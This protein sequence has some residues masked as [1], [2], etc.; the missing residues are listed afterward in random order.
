MPNKEDLLRNAH[1][2]HTTEEFI[3]KTE[4]PFV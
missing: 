3:S 4:T 2:K 1:K